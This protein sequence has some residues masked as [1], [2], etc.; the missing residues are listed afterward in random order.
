MKTLNSSRSY[1]LLMSD[2]ANAP[3][4][5]SLDEIIIDSHGRDYEYAHSLMENLDALLDL[6][7]DE[8]MYFLYSRDNKHSKSVIK[9]IQ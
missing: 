6:K 3:E 4:I 5:K 1:L 8:S 2:S 9:R 7:V